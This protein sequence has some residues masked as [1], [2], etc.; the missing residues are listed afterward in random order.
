[1]IAS[2]QPQAL[3]KIFA[4]LC[5]C[6]RPSGHEERVLQAIEA[7]CQQHQLDY[8]RDDIGNLL[9]R[10][11][12]SL[13]FEDCQGIIMQ[14]H[15]DMVPQKTNSSAHDF[16]R[17]PIT[18]IIDGDWVHAKE[19]TLGADNGMGVAAALAVLIE[20]NLQHGPLEVLLTVDEESGM[21]G[22]QHLR[23]NWLQGDI[24]LNLD[25]EDEGELYVGCAG[26]VDL[27][28]QQTLQ[29]QAMPSAYQTL[30]VTVSGL[31]GGHSGLDIDK[32]R[33]NANLLANQI[34]ASAH[35][36]FNA[37]GIAMKGGTLRNAIARDAQLTLALPQDKVA[38]F[39]SLMADFNTTLNSQYADVETA[40]NIHVATGDHQSQ[41][42]DELTTTRVISLLD[43]CVHGVTRMSDTFTGVVETS[44]N[45]AVVATD[46]NQITIQCMMRSLNNSDRDKLAEQL[47]SALQDLGA[48]VVISGEYPGW[49]PDRESTILTVMQNVHQ[50]LTGELPKVKVIH[51]G[52]ECGLLGEQYPHWDMISFGPTIRH[53]HSPDEKVHIPSVATFWQWLLATIS[54][55]AQGSKA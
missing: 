49:L 23:K 5:E 26:G 53:A 9:I 34:L 33:A 51:A 10:K 48:N 27:T 39:T 47:S 37:F 25:T 54:E 8:Q 4:M 41:V 31:R 42:W 22:A 3:W 21:T 20:P 11:P 30:V 40:I 36:K 52:L 2:L 15:V 50:K 35:S 16:T 14:G 32:G 28:A 6:P 43:H 46:D 13:G 38:D 19:T 55:I 45:V 1:M 7:F 44:N 17:D 18:P 24:L 12:A 29:W